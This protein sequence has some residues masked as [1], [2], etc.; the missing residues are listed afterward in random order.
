VETE[1]NLATRSEGKTAVDTG[2]RRCKASY[3]TTWRL[4][5]IQSTAVV[6][7]TCQDL[8]S[9]EDDVVNFHTNRLN[10]EVVRLSEE[11]TC[12]FFVQCSPSQH[13][14]IT[15]DTIQG[16]YLRWSTFFSTHTNTWEADVRTAAYSHSL[17]AACVVGGL[18]SNC[19]YMHR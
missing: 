9:T 2:K 18:S 17:H 6:Y 4:T 16:G 10:S 3:T 13:D 14:M 7:W 12:I 15:P 1:V 8:T 19:R 5:K 11:T